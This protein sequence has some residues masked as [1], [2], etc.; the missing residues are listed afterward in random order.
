MPTNGGLPAALRLYCRSAVSLLR[1]NMKGPPNPCFVLD[2]GPTATT[3]RKGA[4]TFL[5]EDLGIEP[6]SG[7]SAIEL[8]VLAVRE[9]AKRFNRIEFLLE[10]NA[11]EGIP[12]F[13]SRDMPGFHAWHT[14][15]Q[16]KLIPLTGVLKESAQ[17]KK[18]G[19]MSLGV[20]R[21]E[22]MS[23][24]HKVLAMKGMMPGQ[25]VGHPALP[26]RGLPSMPAVTG[27][28]STASSGFS[29]TALGPTRDSSTT[30]NV[31]E[32]TVVTEAPEPDLFSLFATVAASA[33]SLPP[34][35]QQQRA[36][37]KRMRE[38]YGG[39]GGDL[40]A[41]TAAV[42][43]QSASSAL[44]NALAGILKRRKG[45]GGESAQSA[46]S[47]A[48]PSSAPLPMNTLLSM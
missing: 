19:K 32:A 28:F 6:R 4:Q 29:F 16:M 21:L 24:K 45:A 7:A 41:D 11:Q 35:Q 47:G 34:P 44:E 3:Y 30:T 43:P 9:W 38:A 18:L 5:R 14:F 13:A 42:L 39:A 25:A 10:H 8:S 26:T 23:S 40:V 17:K 12:M 36:A 27:S 37:E 31:S 22:E 2:S 48:A 20:G 46:A 15:V 33:P 1:P